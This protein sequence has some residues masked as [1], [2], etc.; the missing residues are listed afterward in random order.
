MQILT[1]EEISIHTGVLEAKEKNKSNI[2]PL[3]SS[4]DF[5][6]DRESDLVPGSLDT[7]IE[8]L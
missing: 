5:Y 2:N 7:I 4:S 8:L 6:I 1:F 3:R